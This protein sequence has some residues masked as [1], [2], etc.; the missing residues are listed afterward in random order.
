VAAALLRRGAHRLVQTRRPADHADAGT[1]PLRSRNIGPFRGDLQSAVARLGP[2][3]LPT[4]TERTLPDPAALRDR[5][6]IV[7]ERGWDAVDQELEIGRR[8]AA[9]QVFDSGGRAMTALA[10][11]CGTLEC[12]MDRLLGEFLPPLLD[13]A[14][15]ISKAP[16]AGRRDG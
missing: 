8:S 14:R 16:G 15:A 3:P 12:S 1:A 10:L 2:A 7:R 11:S 5:L 9:A 6:A 13:T 4:L